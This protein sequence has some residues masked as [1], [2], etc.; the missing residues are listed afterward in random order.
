[1]LDYRGQSAMRFT[2]KLFI[3]VQLVA[4]FL[5]IL[6]PQVALAY[7]H[8][9]TDE[10][11][12]EA[13]FVGQ[14]VKNVSK[15]LSQYSR[16]L[17]VP[18]KGAHVAE[19]ALSTPYAQVVE[20]SALHSVCYSGQQAAEDYRNRGDFIAVRVK[21]LFTPTFTGRTEDF[22][23]GVSVGLVQKDK[24]MAATSVDGQ[25]IYLEGG[26]GTVI[27]ADVFVRFSVAGVKSDSLI[28]EVVPPEG[29]PVHATFDLNSLR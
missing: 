9:L 13:Y 23:R 2:R 14:D 29:P 5:T 26:D 25:P 6:T 27:G 18:Q 28:V 7:A 10:E 20:T 19:I 1:M 24:H 16:G 22:W 8:P 15:F 17:P 11:V 12:R 4:A 21:V 3:H